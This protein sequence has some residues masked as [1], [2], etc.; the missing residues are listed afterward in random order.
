MRS[1]YNYHA[2]LVKLPTHIL[3][4]GHM[5]TT[6]EW[7]LKLQGLHTWH[8]MLELHAYLIKQIKAQCEIKI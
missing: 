4:C 1:L 5:E 6:F 3:A 7:T 8:M 2:F